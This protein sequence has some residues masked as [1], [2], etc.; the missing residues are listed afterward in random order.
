MDVN[1]RLAMAMRQTDQLT[2]VLWDIYKLT[3]ADTDG[4]PGP[5]SLIAGM[6]MAGYAELVRDDVA[7]LRKERDGSYKSAEGAE[8]WVGQSRTR[9][10]WMLEGGLEECSPESLREQ[11]GILLAEQDAAKAVLADPDADERK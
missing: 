11:L 9:L 8:R 10:A 6:G 4:D 3:G 1:Q 7:G 2:G 5:A